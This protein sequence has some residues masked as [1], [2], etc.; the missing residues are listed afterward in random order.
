MLFGMASGRE[1]TEEQVQGI[2]YLKRVLPLFARL[3][4]NG[5]E[6]DAAGNRRLLMDQYCSL[7]LLF[8]FSPVVDSLRAVQR[9]SD[10][11]KVK[12][13]LG[14]RRVSL[15]SLSEAARVFDPAALE[16]IVEEL[17]Q[18]VRANRDVS[19][20]LVEH[21][22]TAVDGTLCRTLVSLVEAT[23]SEGHG[24][25][26]LHTQFEIDRSVPVRIDVTEGRNRGKSDEREVLANTLQ[27]G[28]CYVMD[29]WYAK[30]KLFNQI[31]AKKSSYVCRVRDNSRVVLEQERELTD[32]A[33]SAGVVRD[34]VVRLGNRSDARTDHPT[35][36]IHVRV[37]PQPRHGSAGIRGSS[38]DGELRIATNLIDVP[39]EVIASI[40]QNRWEVEVFFRF[41]KHVL[42]CRHLISRDSNGVELLAY[43]TIIACLLLAMT[44]GGKPRK[45]TYEM[46]SWR[47]LGVASDEELLEHL[48]KLKPNND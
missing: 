29:R 6:R 17:S 38:S 39:A 25:W 4:A 2:A 12:Q 10:L 27:A 31:H 36:L 41:F 43:C 1:L 40:Y 35:R 30:R 16:P 28:R 33:R 20:G 15:G 9:A 5:C 19:R 13:R 46:I 44:T 22:L 47:M 7:L 37:K 45:A 34:R 18:K 42:G 48:Q 8:L 23:T 11:K 26:R 14:V 24:H 3:R 21:T 32:E